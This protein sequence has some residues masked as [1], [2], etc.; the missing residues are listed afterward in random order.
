MMLART[1][2]VIG[3]SARVYCTCRRRQLWRRRRVP[4]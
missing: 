2:K 1:D 3:W 4:L